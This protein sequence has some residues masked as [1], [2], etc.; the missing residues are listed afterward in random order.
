CP[1]RVLLWINPFSPLALTL[2][3]T[4]PRPGMGGYYAGKFSLY[5]KFRVTCFASVE[6]YEA[7]QT[8]WIADAE[9]MKLVTSDR[10]TFQKDT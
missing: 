7:R 4:F 5:K 3:A 9:A 1:G 10:H 8:F 2:D 6:P